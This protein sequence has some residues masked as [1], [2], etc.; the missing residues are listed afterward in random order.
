MASLLPRRVDGQLMASLPLTCRAVEHVVPRHVDIF[1]FWLLNPFESAGQDQ[2]LH[3]PALVQVG[4][5]RD[6]QGTG[7]EETSWHR[8]GHM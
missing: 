7:Q 2:L 6:Q 5:S 8:D 4:N 1:K 3:L